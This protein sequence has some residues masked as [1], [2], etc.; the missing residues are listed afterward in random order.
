MRQRLSRL[1]FYHW[2]VTPASL[3]F[4]CSPHCSNT[5]LANFGLDFLLV[6]MGVLA[7]IEKLSDD[8]DSEP[9]PVEKRPASKA[10]TQAKAKAVAAAKAKLASQK[11][12]K[13]APKAK[14][15]VK[16]SKS[17]S[18]S[19]KKSQQKSHEA[20][21][22]HEAGWRGSFLKFKK[23][24]VRCYL[25]LLFCCSGSARFWQAADDSA[26]AP[27]SMKRPAACEPEIRVSLPFFY[28]S[29]N[30]WGLKMGKKQILAVLC[31]Q[32]IFSGLSLTTGFG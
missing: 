6:D 1:G 12:K 26:E 22:N 8:S 29:S 30:S 7:P 11:K 15:T 5:T 2:L 27:V 31:Q 18:K 20:E 14:S 21:E 17:K 28:K 32:K 4:C 24:F 23:L 9:A 25:N 16:A 3:F 19:S 10:V 13:F